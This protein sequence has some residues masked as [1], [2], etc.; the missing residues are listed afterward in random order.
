M[1]KK[2]L[3]FGDLH[4]KTYWCNDVIKE[5]SPDE[6]I[7]LGDIFDSFIT[8]KDSVASTCEWL[9]DFIS[10]PNHIALLGNHEQFYR[11]TLVKQ[12]V[13]SGNTMEKM[14]QINDIITIDDWNTLKL[15]YYDGKYLYSHAGI[16]KEHFEHPVN[17][18]T[19]DGITELCDK[20]I[21]NANAGCAHPILRAGMGRGGSERVGGITW[22]CNMTESSAINGWNQLVGHTPYHSLN[23]HGRIK[24]T[25]NKKYP[26]GSIES[27]DFSG[28]YYTTI[29]DGKLEYKSTGDTGYNVSN[30]HPQIRRI[31]KI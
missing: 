28:L 8:T 10:K 22:L 18:I 6:V 7:Q 16:S 19:I 24:Y 12:F 29:T 5:E 20:A 15:F 9:Q 14:V 17:G 11:W 30:N 3:I 21:D 31:D 25:P 26:L 13:C 27:L 4:E 1:S 23:I 2:Q